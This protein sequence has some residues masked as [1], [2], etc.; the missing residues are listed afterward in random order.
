MAVSQT[1]Q[2]RGKLGEHVST[3]GV[4]RERDGSLVPLSQTAQLLF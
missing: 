4:E 1:Q 2:E 3:G